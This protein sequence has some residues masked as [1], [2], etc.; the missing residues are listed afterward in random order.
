M[1]QKFPMAILSLCATSSES[2]S[3]SKQTYVFTPVL[4]QLESEPELELERPKLLPQLEL[5]RP[6]LLPI[7]EEEVELDREEFPE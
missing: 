3:R 4:P 5:E 6:E 2:T 1:P 7:F